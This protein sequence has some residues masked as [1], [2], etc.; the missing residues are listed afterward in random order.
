MNRHQQ[1]SK[2]FHR[3][4]I[5][6]I[7]L[8]IIKDQEIV[9]IKIIMVTPMLRHTQLKELALKGQIY[10]IVIIDL[11]TLIKTLIN[12]QILKIII[13]TLPSLLS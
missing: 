9:S 10:R 5:Q 11:Q 8:I 4:G 7:T 2:Q 3:H 1:L 13:A 6:I 12:P